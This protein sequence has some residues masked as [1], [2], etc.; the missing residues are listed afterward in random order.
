ME[1][2]LYLDREAGSCLYSRG[3]WMVD[4]C[5]LWNAT[6]FEE[7]SIKGFNDV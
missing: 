4:N 5:L 6:L 2:E 3:G 7:T 1:N